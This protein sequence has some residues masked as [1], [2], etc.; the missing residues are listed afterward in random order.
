MKN[1]YFRY[2]A[3]LLTLTA[4]MASGLASLNSSANDDESYI[5]FPND[6]ANV[7]TNDSKLQ[8]A[9]TAPLTNKVSMSYTPA[10]YEIKTLP[11]INYVDLQ[12]ENALLTSGVDAI[13]TTGHQMD[14]IFN[15]DNSAPS[16]WK[17]KC[18]SGS[19]EVQI[20]GGS[21]NRIK[22]ADNQCNFN[23]GW[24]NILRV[25]PGDGSDSIKIKT[26]WD[27][28]EKGNGDPDK[29]NGID[30]LGL[31]NV[32]KLR[33]QKDT[34]TIGLA[35]T[36][37]SKIQTIFNEQLG[38]L[39]KQ[40]PN[41]PGNE[42]TPLNGGTPT[43]FTKAEYESSLNW[44]ILYNVGADA[45][46][47]FTIDVSDK[48]QVILFDKDA[49]AQKLFGK[50]TG[51]TAV[52]PDNTIKLRVFWDDGAPEDNP[53]YVEP[54]SL[55]NQRTETELGSSAGT[56][57]TNETNSF[58]GPS[59]DTI[60][61]PSGEFSIKWYK[62]D[63]SAHK[64]DKIKV[65]WEGFE[66]ENNGVAF[67]SD[68]P[69]EGTEIE[70][71][72][73]DPTPLDYCSSDDELCLEAFEKCDGDLECLEKL[74]DCE[75]DE[76]CIEDLLDELEE[77]TDPTVPKCQESCFLRACI[78]STPF[79]DPHPD[80]YLDKGDSITYHVSLENISPI[81][82]P[83][84]LNNLNLGFNPPIFTTLD[85]SHFSE[86]IPE[87]GSGSYTGK[88][89]GRIDLVESLGSG[90]KFEKN[91]LVQVDEDTL[92]EDYDITTENRIVAS[93]TNN[94]AVTLKPL[95]HHVGDGAVNVQV[96]RCYAFDYYGGEFQCS[97]SCETIEPGTRITVRDTL[98]N[99][100]GATAY[101]HTYFPPPLSP[102]FEYE[103]NSIRIDH[104]ISGISVPN[105]GQTFPPA[106]GVTI[107]GPIESNG[108]RTVFFNYYIP[109]DL[110]ETDPP[111]NE[112]E[113][114]GKC[115]P[116]DDELFQEAAEGGS[117]LPRGS[118]GREGAAYSPISYESDCPVDE[119]SEEDKN[120]LIC[121]KVEDNPKLTVELTAIPSANN[122]VYQG[123]II[124]YIVRVTNT[125]KQPVANL[126]IEGLVP[127]QTT[128]KS[129]NCNG[130]NISN[131]PELQTKGSYEYSFT[132][133]VSEN[134]T[135]SS[136]THPGQHIIYKGES[137]QIFEITSNSV[138]HALISALEPTGDFT[139]DITLNR[140]IVL[141]SK[142]RTA[143]ADQGDQSKV[144]HTFQYTGTNK[145]VYPFL[146]NGSAPPHTYTRNYCNEAGY[147]G[148][149]ST[150]DAPFNS[151]LYL[152]NSSSSIR[153]QQL[154]SS[155]QMSN[156][157]LNFTITT[158]L[159]SDRPEFL[160]TTGR[161]SDHQDLIN[162]QVS[163][164]RVIQD[165]INAV[166]YFMKNGGEIID[167]YLLDDGR[168]IS[169]QLMSTSDFRAVADG[170]GGEINTSNSGSSTL[171]KVFEDTWMYQQVGNRPPITCSRRCGK[172]TCY[173]YPTPPEYKWVLFSSRVIPLVTT[174]KDYITTLTSVAW[175]QT[176][177]GHMGFGEDFWDII[178]SSGNPNWVQLSDRSLATEMKLY[179]PPNEH[180]ADFIIYSPHKSDPLKSKLGEKIASG[181]FDQGFLENGTLSRGEA[182]DRDEF[183]RDYMDDLLN[184]QVYGKVIR[185]NQA[186]TSPSGMTVNGGTLQLSGTVSFSPDTIYYFKGDAIIGNGTSDVT[187]SG[188]RAR[189]VIEG[190]V[191]LRS[192]ILYDRHSGDLTSIPSVRLHSTGNISI[193]PNVTDVELMM[194]AEQAFHSGRSDQQLRI[195]GDVIAY[196]AFWE[197]SPLN[198]ERDD[199]EMVNKPSEII[200][201]DF[202]KYILTP[203]GDKKLPDSGYFWR[204]VNGGE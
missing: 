35:A 49:D 162:Y 101:N 65:I 67:A 114:D 24:S 8:L 155:S 135:G 91:L 124:T 45:K 182:Y 75:G 82:S 12:I 180:N 139:H 54:W 64:S 193:R 34:G 133:Q 153:F 46:F 102:S 93:A 4:L 16:S 115:Y 23:A 174:D 175:L 154:L 187:L 89:A 178:P 69:V 199:E 59:G 26:V 146:S 161:G 192:N 172:S 62:F 136:I 10:T 113:Q 36:D 88:G 61:D 158:D 92:L 165:G 71:P 117:P 108:S 163:S 28:D 21:T 138:T 150:Y 99:Q 40:I 7:H 200:Y 6:G 11:G 32:F 183:P 25:Y 5:F 121:V 188:G 74:K 202:R 196:K 184:K 160:S 27:V 130:V 107:P 152:Y 50:E 167:G 68:T 197:R 201:E 195:L 79:P 20:A 173:Y 13:N 94:S 48:N 30:G 118:G 191:D 137:E 56:R 2:S 141:N 177:N 179:T 189:L 22:I 159:P 185:L 81:D 43:L 55:L 9:L 170:L 190:N 169:T 120:G 186:S 168:N 39:F 126:I 204:E 31:I 157:D 47:V 181:S 123:S 112:E 77:E 129:G 44:T 52:P 3:L 125:T 60:Q 151:T 198:Q 87:E 15:P 17:V 143:R 147:N 171:G 66:V 194:L 63:T 29:K 51:K 72:E 53:N 127:P 37:T 128:C 145:Q 98:T 134:A 103:A 18:L 144:I 80:S 73:E 95:I 104:P 140:R 203:P 100:G 42:L 106:D 109:D 156:V 96:T 131:P 38:A 33:T 132:V 116:K 19:T 176:K 58:A 76:Q 166:N 110:L 14:L 90:E 142:D 149:S 83:V 70:I 97:N 148:P 84:E 105:D 164:G 111:T 57:G 78:S 119:G 122:T 86:I 85:D 1:R 41:K